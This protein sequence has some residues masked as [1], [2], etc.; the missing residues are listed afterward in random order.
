MGTLGWGQATLGPCS[1]LP[2]PC[3]GYLQAVF[4]DD[5]DSPQ[6]VLREPEKQQRVQQLVS[7]RVRA[8]DSLLC[9]APPFPVRSS[10]F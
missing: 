7:P 3:P 9:E 2:S 10:W 4:Q 6:V 8:R 1:L 5:V